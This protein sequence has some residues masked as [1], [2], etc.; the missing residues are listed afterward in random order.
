MSTFPCKNPLFSPKISLSGQK[1]AAEQHLIGRQPLLGKGNGK[2]QNF[3]GQVHHRKA[4]ALQRKAHFLRK[5]AGFSLRPG[6]M[7]AQTAAP[8]GQ[9]Q[10]CLLYT[11][12]LPRLLLFCHVSSPFPQSWISPKRDQVVC[13]VTLAWTNWPIRSSPAPFRR[14]SFWPWVRAVRGYSSS[15]L[16]Y[17][18][19]CV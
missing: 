5:T 10:A 15:C 2:V 11:S 3:P 8:M 9:P 19:R 7:G 13:F 17:T 18:S 12:L 14:S 4:Q 16:L 6:A 1:Q